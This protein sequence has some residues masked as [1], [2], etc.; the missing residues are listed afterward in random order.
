VA[1]HTCRGCSRTLERQE[2][3]SVHIRVRV[4]EARRKVTHSVER[5]IENIESYWSYIPRCHSVHEAVVGAHRRR[6]SVA[7]ASRGLAVGERIRF[8][9]S[10][11]HSAP[12][13]SNSP[14]LGDVMKERRARCALLR[15]TNPRISHQHRDFFLERAIFH[16]HPCRRDAKKRTFCRC[17]LSRRL[18][19]ASPELSL[20]HGRPMNQEEITHVSDASFR[21]LIE[22][23]NSSP[24]IAS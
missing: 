14:S 15:A 19:R 12:A 17:T 6:L 22:N 13:N 21:R 2:S 18:C 4:G 11:A 20:R 1:S 3:R 9:S 23:R 7:P 5:R 8:T 24:P 16:S 10:H